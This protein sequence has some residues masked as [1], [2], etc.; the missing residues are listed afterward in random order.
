MT[1]EVIPKVWGV[2]RQMLPTTPTTIP[3]P[4]KAVNE[5]ESGA[6]RGQGMEWCVYHAGKMG[7]QMDLVPDYYTPH[8]SSE[9]WSH[10]SGLLANM[11]IS[12]AAI[13]R[14]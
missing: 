12:A 8:S 3:L 11:G 4:F 6:V 1:R 9:K 10:C 13:S 5:A 7:G 2:F 14:V